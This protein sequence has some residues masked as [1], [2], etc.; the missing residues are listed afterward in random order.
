MID[1]MQNVLLIFIEVMCC[2]SFFETFGAIRYKGWINFIQ[3]LLLLSSMCFYSY[4]FSEYFVLRQIIAISVF[5]VFMFWH[6]RISLKKSLVLAMLFDALLLAMDYLAY[7]IIGMLSLDSNL[8]EQQYGIGAVLA[9]LL[10][11]VIL[12]F[13]ILVIRKQFGK[14]S[15]EM[16]LDTEWLRFLFFPVFTIA[17]ISAMLSVFKYVQTVEQANLLA[18]IAFGMVGMNIV[19]FYLINDIVEREMKM[20]ENKV[21]QIQAKNQLEMYRSISENFDNQKRKTHEYKNQISCI[22]SLLDKKQYS[23]LEEYVK[24]IYGC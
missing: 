9:Y 24:K 22:E 20:H 4:G 8:S 5:S 10:V 16:M 17:A 13:L 11:K 15:M 21:F 6:V 23:K 14:K 3:I 2:K 12:F 1:L 18:V 19:V 7:L